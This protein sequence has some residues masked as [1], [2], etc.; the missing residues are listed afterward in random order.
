MGRHKVECGGLTIEEFLNKK[1]FKTDF[2]K[3]DSDCQ[4]ENILFAI[5]STVSPRPLVG[6]G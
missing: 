1:K 6:L 4:F 3:I 5:L 2:G